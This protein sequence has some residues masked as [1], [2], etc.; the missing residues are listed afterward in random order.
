MPKFARRKE[1]VMNKD[2][3]KGKL[4][5]LKE[6]MKDAAE[7]LKN[8]AKPGHHEE[9]SEGR[10]GEPRSAGGAREETPEVEREIPGVEE[11]EDE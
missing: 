3:L 10:G 5:N 8:K 4:G 7:S 1:S 9:G 2:E 6:K 11:S